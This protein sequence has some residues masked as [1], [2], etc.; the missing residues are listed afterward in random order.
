[1]SYFSACLV[2]V[3]SLIVGVAGTNVRLH[4][5]EEETPP[6]LV[7]H[8]GELDCTHV[9]LKGVE[10]DFLV[11]QSRFVLCCRFVVVSAL[12]SC[13][14]KSLGQS[15]ANLALSAC[16]LNGKRKNAVMEAIMS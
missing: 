2:L 15:Q 6:W 3:S 1:L 8:L 9:L 11:R 10:G 12:A 14:T 16:L 7:S 4:V 13:Q 5:V